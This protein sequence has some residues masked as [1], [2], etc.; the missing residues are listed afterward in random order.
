MSSSSSLLA[1]A[2]QLKYVEIW[3]IVGREYTKYRTR[4]DGV[5]MVQV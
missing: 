4:G 3:Q 1:G 5:G 2:T